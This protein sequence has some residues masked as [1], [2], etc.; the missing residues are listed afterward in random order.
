MALY[1]S[2]EMKLNSALREN[3]DVN[4]SYLKMRNK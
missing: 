1:E 2:V 3:D 4:N